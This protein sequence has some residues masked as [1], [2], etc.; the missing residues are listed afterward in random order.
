[1]ADNDIFQ[2]DKSNFP[3]REI[4]KVIGV[5]GGG[6]NAL[7]HIVRGGVS[8]VEFIAVNTDIAHLELSEAQKRM[9][10]GKEL[11]KGL[12]AGANPEIGGKAAQESRDDIRL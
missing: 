3:S 12:G 6:N 8:S 4:I 9:V 11:T 5:G 2:L 10:I 7:N 1:M